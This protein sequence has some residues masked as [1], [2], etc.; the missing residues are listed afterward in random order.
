MGSDLPAAAKN[1]Q[2]PAA[3][4]GWTPDYSRYAPD[5]GSQ[6]RGAVER[7]IYD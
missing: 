2:S 6:V 7:P 3:G 4:G 1:F 5:L